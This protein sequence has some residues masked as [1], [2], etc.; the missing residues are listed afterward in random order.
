MKAVIKELPELR[1]VGR[2][3]TKVNDKILEM[4]SEWGKFFQDINGKVEIEKCDVSF[5]I[6]S[7]VDMEK[8]IF[9]YMIGLKKEVYT[10]IPEEFTEEVL[11]ANKYAVY[12]FKGKIDG[13]NVTEFMNNIFYKWMPEEKLEVALNIC[14]EYYDS[15][16]KDDSEESEFDVYVPIK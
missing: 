8:K 16:W 1:I 13:E 10:K 15:R 7:N 3:F 9:D 12:T 11:P 14:L 5:G 4:T 6:S 2:K